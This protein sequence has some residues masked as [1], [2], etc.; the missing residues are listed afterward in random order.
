MKRHR[1]GGVLILSNM[2]KLTIYRANERQIA[3]TKVRLRFA[4]KCALNRGKISAI[5]TASDAIRIHRKR[6]QKLR[7][8]YTL[9]DR[10]IV[11]Y[12]QMIEK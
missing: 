1:I 12:K 8:Y 4:K 7:F 11:L 6:T 3:S 2:Q 10:I 5:P 9:Q